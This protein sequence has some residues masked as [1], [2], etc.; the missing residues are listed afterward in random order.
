MR[1]VLLLSIVI[2]RATAIG[3][4]DPT[5]QE[6]QGL[7]VGHQTIR[8][9][10]GSDVGQMQFD[11]QAAQT[12]REYVANSLFTSK[13]N[14]RDSG[15]NASNYSES[16]ARIQFCP[17]G[18]FV[19]ALSGYINIDVEGMSVTS[20]DQSSNM[21]GYWEV[22]SLPNGMHI[23]LFYSTHPTMLEDSPNGFLPF[24]VASYTTDFVSLPNGD[25]Y[26]RTA[27]QFCN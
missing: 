21:T 13:S 18:T 4:T 20:G 6:S 23:I 8:N 10:L 16:T 15:Y 12:F 9:L 7:P 2:I 22:A 27:H 17:D 24:P 11:S 19:Q 1:L 25:G 3:Q 5:T 14:N 26:A